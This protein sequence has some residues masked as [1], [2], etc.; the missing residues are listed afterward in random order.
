MLCRPADDEH[1]QHVGHNRHTR[2][3][4]QVG[5]IACAKVW[6]AGQV[7]WA[8]AARVYEQLPKDQHPDAAD[9]VSTAVLKRTWLHFLQW[10]DVGD[11]PRPGRPVLISRQDALAAS[12]LLKKG[13]SLIKH[14]DGGTIQYIV[15]FTTVNEAIRLLPQLKDIIDKYDVSAHQLYHAMKREDP[16]L[17]RRSVVLRPAFTE[18][19][20]QGRISWCLDTLAQMG[21]TT[22][23]QAGFLARVVQVDEGK[24]S[25]TTKSKAHVRVYHDSRE[26]MLHDY[27]CL[28]EVEGE[29]ELSV[30]FVICVS[31]HPGFASTNGLVYFEFTTGTDYIRRLH[32]TKGQTADEAFEYMVSRF[33]SRCVCC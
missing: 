8:D 19:Q 29:E 22:A 7:R 27:V 9:K 5:V 14:V 17:E 25:Y 32:N 6:E 3:T 21:E 2:D 16:Y 28:P 10:G 15:Y 26:P 31:P 13:K 11:A 24:V 30:H 18:Q 33:T 23:E 20:K 12:E 1:E 4:R